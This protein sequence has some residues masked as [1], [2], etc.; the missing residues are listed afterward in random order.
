MS[1]TCYWDDISVEPN[2]YPILQDEEYIIRFCIHGCDL[3]C[4]GCPYQSYRG[5]RFSGSA[6]ELLWLIAFA[7]QS[8]SAMFVTGGEFLHWDY[9]LPLLQA[10]ESLSTLKRI[11]VGTSGFH[12]MLPPLPGKTRLLWDL[13]GPSQ[14]CFDETLLTT[15]FTNLAP[16]DVLQFRI[17]CGDDAEFA[18]IIVREGICYKPDVRVL[19]RDYTEQN[20][21]AHRI[22]KSLKR[23]YPGIVDIVPISVDSHCMHG[24]DSTY[25][26]RRLFAAI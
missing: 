25:G 26:L 13:K 5:N 11:V 15:S 1:I 22:V 2:Q 14:P 18:E 7:S 3:D 17:S 9:A 6:A 19:L 23:D 21:K 8:S 4:P 16:G 10:L 12:N 20:S 24:G